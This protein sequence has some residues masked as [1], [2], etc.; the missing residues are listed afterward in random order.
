M[1]AGHPNTN[2]Y[3]TK[4]DHLIGD[5]L[6]SGVRCFNQISTFEQVEQKLGTRFEAFIVAIK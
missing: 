4:M 2:G 6:I 3:G 1:I 5:V